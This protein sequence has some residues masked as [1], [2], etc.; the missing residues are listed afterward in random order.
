ME[1]NTESSTNIKSLHSESKSSNSYNTDSENLPA[2]HIGPSRTTP[3]LIYITVELDNFVLDHSSIADHPVLLQLKITAKRNPY[4]TWSREIVYNGE[5]ISLLIAGMGTKVDDK[6]LCKYI[7]PEYDSKLES[8]FL[9]VIEAF[10][11]KHFCLDPPSGLWTF[12][13]T[14]NTHLELQRLKIAYTGEVF[15]APITDMTITVEKERSDSKS[16]DTNENELNPSFVSKATKV[17][18][19]VVLDVTMLMNSQ[20]TPKTLTSQNTSVNHNDDGEYV[21]ICEIIAVH[22]LTDISAPLL[23]EIR[24]KAQKYVVQYEENCESEN[25]PNYSTSRLLQYTMEDM[26]KYFLESSSTNN[27]L[28]E[29]AVP[30]GIVLNTTEK[31]KNK[32]GKAKSGIKK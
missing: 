11:T 2:D 6:I 27:S 28:N 13:E 19:C 29:D 14:T 7:K 31:P 25:D 3:C 20:N 26:Y 21:A 32:R 8:T 17:N 23:N 22:S 15:I 10:C 12:K 30:D 16:D 1:S 18:L 5:G 24:R 4:D 9:R